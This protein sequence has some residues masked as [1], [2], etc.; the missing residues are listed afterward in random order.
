MR[1]GLAVIATSLTALLVACGG[2]E[3]P[4]RPDAGPSRT[5][6]SPAERPTAAAFPAAS[7][8]S[9][10][11]IA[12][13]AKAGPQVGLATSVIV[14][15]RQRLAFGLI[16]QSGKLLELPAAVYVA[17]SPSG[18]A[19]GPFLAPQDPLTVAPEFRSKTGAGSGGGV[20][21][22]Y[23][24]DVRFPR[25]GRYAVLV[26]ASQAG[27]LTGAATQVTVR[28]RA[29]VPAIGQPAPR[30]ATDTVASAGGDIAKI[31]TRVPPDDMHKVS[32]DDVLG[33]RPVAILFSA[34]SQCETRTC[35]P[36]L[37]VA[38]QLDRTYGRQM[39]FIHQEPYAGNQER[40]GLNRPA[41]AFGL[42]TEPWLFTIDRRGRIA[43]RLE[44]AF[45]VRAFTRAVQAALR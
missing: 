16:D 40:N 44:G 33:K 45:G 31:D 42:P 22:I 10:Q 30:I 28:R 34:P 19:Q 24:A 29:P 27:Q 8:E 37:D 20:S 4:S 11:A 23:G 12:D 13:Q 7:G 43:A 35:G 39:T 2:D 41:K 26:L 32:L 18:R 38:A 21:A 5:E 17:R 9:L 1:G 14:P 25:P 15:G 3:S 36:V 6:P